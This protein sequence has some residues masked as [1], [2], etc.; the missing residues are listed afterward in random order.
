MGTPE[1]MAHEQALGHSLDGRADVY[2]LGCVGYWLLT[3]HLVFKKDTPMQTLLAH[4]QEAPPALEQHLK[5][6]VPRGLRLAILDCLAKSPDHRPQTAR[7]LW[8]LLVEA[9]R[10]LSAEETWND[11]RAHAWWR[12]HQ[13]PVKVS[14]PS[15]LTPSPREVLHIAHAPRQPS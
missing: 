15:G 6:P 14:N 4:I 13:P 7:D 2:A 1:F 5:A 12:E 9:E 3:G 10:E 8:R 11:E